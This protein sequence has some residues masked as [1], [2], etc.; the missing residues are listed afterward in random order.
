[1]CLH[2]D[3]GTAG[4]DQDLGEIDVTRVRDHLVDLVSADDFEG[5]GRVMNAVADHLVAG[6]PEIWIREGT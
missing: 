3:V 4:T 1:M 2:I 5:M 6:H